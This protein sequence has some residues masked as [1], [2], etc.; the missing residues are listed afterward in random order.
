MSCMIEKMTVGASFDSDIYVN[1]VYRDMLAGCAIFS[2]ER[3]MRD[4][5]ASVCLDDQL[6]CELKGGFDKSLKFN[7]CLIDT[8]TISQMPYF[9]RSEHYGS[10]ASNG[11][12]ILARVYINT[13][14][15]DYGIPSTNN[16]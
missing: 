4:L 11:F 6:I 14:T 16:L 8:V 9:I 15:Y 7:H 3:D 2:N 10:I 1:T 5:W 12:T 13:M